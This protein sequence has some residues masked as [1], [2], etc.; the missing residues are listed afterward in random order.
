MNN[1]GR[2]NDTLFEQ[3]ERLNESDLEGEALE[4]EVFRG[5]AIGEVAKSIISNGS[6]VLEARKFRDDRM[7]I[8]KEA[9]KMLEG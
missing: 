1:L 5:K 2:L 9:P 6:L 3:L 4:R 8:D 7:D